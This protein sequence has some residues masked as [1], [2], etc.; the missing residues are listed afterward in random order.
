MFAY[1]EFKKN[2]TAQKIYLSAKKLF[3]QDGIEKTSVRS[4][5]VD[6]GVN[7]GSITYHFKEKKDIAARIYAQV[8]NEMEAFFPASDNGLLSLHDYFFF[9]MLHMKTLIISPAFHELFC[10][11][12]DQDSINQQYFEWTK[13]YICQYAYH[14]TSDKDFMIVTPY[15]LK[16]FMRELS[17]VYHSFSE[18]ERPSSRS[19]IDYYMDYLIQMIFPPEVRDGYQA[20]DEYRSN[21]LDE[22]DYW[23]V[24]LVKSYTPV[25]IHLDTK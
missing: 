25:F 24:D 17:N 21:L 13:Q 19:L 7:L 5:A 1:K 6:A 8:C 10:C 12:I 20:L 15:M 3:F 23:Y 16:G 2:S 22:F 9:Q 11:S 14:D 18:S 4:L